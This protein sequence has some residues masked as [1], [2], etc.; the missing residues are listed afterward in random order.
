MSR[1]YRMPQLTA[2]VLAFTLASPVVAADKQ[3][4]ERE[5]DI[6]RFS[7]AIVDPLEKVV[8]DKE[9]F[10]RATQKLRADIESV[11]AKYDIADKSSQRQFLNSLVQLDFLAGNYD[12]A[13][14]GAEAVRALEE[15]PADKLL[16][17]LRLRAM[18]A[19]AKQTGGI[20]NPAYYEAVA[21]TIRTELDT[22]PFEVIVNDIK[23]YKAGAE[24][25]G[26]GRILGNV[27]D[28]LQA[29]LDKTGALS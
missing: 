7:Y 9:T 19:A 1:N 27:R 2:L 14:A 12:A 24:T 23:N 21:T 18:V 17:G 4:I 3:R 28:V 26:E 15:K 16:S 29:A 10:E 20:N 8:Q 6:P 22:L 13:L 25:I 5:A 11:L